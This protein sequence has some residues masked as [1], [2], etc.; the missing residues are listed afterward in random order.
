VRVAEA[1]EAFVWWKLPMPRLRQHSL[2]A[3]VDRARP[4]H[5]EAT[6]QKNLALIP[7]AHRRRLEESG[8][9]VVP[10]YRRIR[11]GRQVLELRFD[12]VAGCLRTP[13]GGSSRQLLVLREGARYKTRLLT[14]VEA[15]RLMGAPRKFK[16]PGSDTEAYRAMGDAVAV[17]VAAFLARHLLSKL[18]PVGHEST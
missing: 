5:D 17:P 9:D 15:A 13:A 10:G 11:G 12:D 18:I 16:L 2:S 14:A 3:I 7:D 1:A 4:C 6:S 8:L